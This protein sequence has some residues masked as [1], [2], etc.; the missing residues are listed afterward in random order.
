V[1]S[2]LERD[3]GKHHIKPDH[4]MELAA[5]VA[6]DLWRQGQCLIEAE[7]LETWFGRWLRADDDLRDRYKDLS[8]GK[9][10]EDLR[11]PTCLSRQDGA[12][13]NHSG[14][15]FAHTLMQEFFVAQY[16]FDVLRSNEPQRWP[17]RQPSNETLDFLGQMLSEARD[18][19]ASKTDALGTLSSW[20]KSYLSLTSELL[21]AYALRVGEKGWPMP[22]LVGIDMRGAKPMGWQFK[23]PQGQARLDVSAARFDGAS[24]REAC[25]E[26]VRLQG[27]RLDDASMEGAQFLSCDLSRAV[28]EQAFTSGTVA[29]S[30]TLSGANF[31]GVKV[32]RMQFL[33]CS[34]L[35][36]LPLCAAVAPAGQLD[37][38]RLN[39][40]LL[41][42]HE[43]AVKSCAFSADGGPVVSAGNDGTVRLWDAHAGELLRVTAT[44]AHGHG[45]W[46]PSDNRVIEAS[47]DAWRWMGWLDQDEN[48]MP[49]RLPLEHFGLVPEPKRL[50]APGT[51][52]PSL[53]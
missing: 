46:T 40:A 17:M 41:P 16:L 3:A 26:S 37:P 4:K 27:A 5:H 39:L 24:L 20:R 45:V 22:V 11:N 14:F 38:R 53:P 33:Q 6:A 34:D 8:R 32:H 15:R 31:A 49:T 50:L 47:G 42:G 52:S 28:F 10:E 29:H 25:F 12:T 35:P 30:S 18:G 43:G 51:P 21:L 19:G 9:L 1:R 23:A 44:S 13:E 36:A 2:W 48:G 7:Q